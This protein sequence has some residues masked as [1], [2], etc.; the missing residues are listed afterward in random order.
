MKTI[1]AHQTDE[2]FA[3]LLEGCGVLG[4]RPESPIAMGEIPSEKPVYGR[5]FHNTK[6]VKSRL[7]KPGF[8]IQMT[9]S[10][11]KA[12]WRSTCQISGMTIRNQTIGSEIITPK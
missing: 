7:S 3:S 9:P 6:K 4:R 10:F 2:S 11:R 1:A 12:G 5:A 8:L